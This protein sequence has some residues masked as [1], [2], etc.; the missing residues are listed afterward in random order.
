MSKEIDDLLKNLKNNPSKGRMSGIDAS[1]YLNK[2]EDNEVDLDQLDAKLVSINKEIEKDFGVKMSNVFDDQSLSQFEGIE[3]EVNAIVIGQI[4]FI[5][6]LNIAFK[7]PF[8]MGK[9]KERPLNC[10]LV[11]GQKGSGKHSAL[12]SYVK[13]MHSR[14]LI[15]SSKIEWIDGSLYTSNDDEKLFIQDLYMAF[16]GTSSVVVFE[17]IE[18]LS[19]AFIPMMIEMVEK[20]TITLKKRYALQN[21]QLVEASNM[22]L[23]SAIGN[24]NALD[25]YL[26][27]LTNQKAEKLSSS[28]GSA[29]TKSISDVCVSRSLEVDS[30]QIIADRLLKNL[31]KQCLSRLNY[32]VSFD[33]SF[34]EYYRAQY[35]NDLGVPSLIQVSNQCFSALSNYKLA[36]TTSAMSITLSYQDRI[37]VDLEGVKQELMSFEQSINDQEAFVVQEELDEIVGL[38]EVKDYILALE[39]NVKM[40]KLRAQS[41]LKNVDVSMHMIFTGNPGTG[42]T[43]IARIVAKYL[44]AMDVIE[45]GQLIEVTRADLVGRYVGHTAPLTQQVIKSALGGVLFVDEAYALYR[46]KDDSFGLE[47]IDTLVK[48]ME[49]YRDQL[50]V[51]LA[52]YSKEMSD[53]LEANSGLKSRFPNVIEFKDY[54][55]MELFEISESICKGK[56]YH[57]NEECKQPLLAY[58]ERK[59]K[60]DAKGNGN[61]RM[62]RN[63]VE[64]AILNQSKRYMVEKQGDL[65][66]LKR[67]DFDLD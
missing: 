33:D 10:M 49:D 27:F 64:E 8:V 26:V 38:K 17:N 42:K 23:S 40:Q 63:L 16:S 11:S 30:V 45:G 53:F 39:N 46:G 43:T 37:L 24:I 31:G 2:L 52:G 6:Q 9:N 67:C 14:K 4:E 18:K 35:Q 7:R 55:A 61:G 22:L 32:T 51:I 34:K 57:L 19:K 20:G 58:Y 1:T 60:E 36:H 48:G 47:A 54:T 59:Q 5:K 3:N 28:L 13:S 15:K 62:A 65:S 66:E 44:K 29:F 41:G 56:D 25:K 50:I 21:N 12:T